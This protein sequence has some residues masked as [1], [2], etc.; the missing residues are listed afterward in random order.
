MR[1]RRLQLLALAF[2]VLS[3][4]AARP[5]WPAEADLRLLV[6]LSS[7]QSDEVDDVIDLEIT[8]YRGGALRYEWSL[9]FLREE[10]CTERS[11]FALGQ[12]TP[13]QVQEL[14]RVL[15]AVR[16]GQLTGSCHLHPSGLGFT[17]SEISW[18]GPYGDRSSHIKLAEGFPDIGPPLPTCTDRR[19]EARD[20]ILA[21]AQAALARPQTRI[22]QGIACFPRR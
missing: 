17:F 1:S 8:V 12:A 9:S 13:A 20:A 4:I 5:A 16:I 19:D 7:Q 3:A 21:F 18:K 2:F 6:K 11:T 10:N 15:A 14:E 22:L